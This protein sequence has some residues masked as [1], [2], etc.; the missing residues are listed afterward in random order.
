M[1]VMRR[2]EA[3][4]LLAGVAITWPLV[5]RAQQKTMPVIGFLHSLSANRSGANLAAFREGLSQAGY[6]EG[7]SITIE[8]RWADGHYDKLPELAADLVGRNVAVIVTGGG[9]PAALAAKRATSTIPIVF[10]IAS[11]PVESGIVKSLARPEGN[12][13]GIS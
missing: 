5:A 7:E 6:V 9:S 1:V 2:R 3:F 4:A 11:D 13:T 10:A 8:Y 12:I